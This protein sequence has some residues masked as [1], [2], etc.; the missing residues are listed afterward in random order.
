M[1]N[2]RFGPQTVKRQLFN[3][4]PL[5]DQLFENMQTVKIEKSAR[6]TEVSEASDSQNNTIN[7]NAVNSGRCE[8][9]FEAMCDSVFF[10]SADPL[11][12]RT[13]IRWNNGCADLESDRVNPDL[14]LCR[15]NNTDL[16]EKIRAVNNMIFPRDLNPLILDAK[17]DGYF[18]DKLNTLIFRPDSEVQKNTFIMSL[19][20][21][22]SKGNLMSRLVLITASEL[23]GLSLGDKHVARK[24]RSKVLRFCNPQTKIYVVG[25]VFDD[26]FVVRG[27]KFGQDAVVK[28]EAAMG[29]V[30][31]VPF[32]DMHF[33]ILT[34]LLSSQVIKSRPDKTEE[35]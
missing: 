22:D 32:F 27:D 30:T 31:S 6:F 14:L 24:R 29:L 28:V 34:Q 10:T 18:E 3:S 13:K 15:T 4:T 8:D 33:K 5:E 21:Y 2:V 7:N 9:F 16:F 35:V 20:N 1:E 12:L 11:K 17:T 19:D 25:V 26:F 23:Q